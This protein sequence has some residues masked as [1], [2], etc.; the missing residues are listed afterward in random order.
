MTEQRTALHSKFW[1]RTR[2]ELKHH[3]QRVRS[4]ARGRKRRT[5]RELPQRHGGLHQPDRRPIRLV[6]AGG[7]NLDI[8]EADEQP[9][10]RPVPRHVVKRHR[11][12]RPVKGGGPDAVENA[13][14]LVGAPGRD[15]QGRGPDG[16]VGEGVVRRPRRRKGAGRHRD[17]R[18]VDEPGVDAGVGGLEVP[19]PRGERVEAE[20]EPA[21]E[22]RA[23]LGR[24]RAQAGDELLRVRAAELPGD[25][26]VAVAA[27][28]ARDVGAEQGPLQVDVALLVLAELGGRVL[29]RLAHSSGQGRNPG[30]GVQCGASSDGARIRTRISCIR[31]RISILILQMLG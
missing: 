7:A 11:P 30:T 24:R 29:V 14:R 28:D 31:T 6:S 23:Q 18:V 9:G 3:T 15:A 27:A 1:Q 17:Q 12:R 21:E 4:A 8:Q 2:A 13:G 19:P 5:L 25:P 22:E 10:R 26:G 20:D 16:V